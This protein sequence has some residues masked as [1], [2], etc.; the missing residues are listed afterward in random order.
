MMV[1]DCGYPTSTDSSCLLTNQHLNLVHRAHCLV[2]Q[3]QIYHQKKK[4]DRLPS[5][6]S[7]RC[8]GNRSNLHV[9]KSCGD[10]MALVP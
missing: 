8:G 4:H 3:S 10:C 5:R 7:L 6:I 9:M 2:N 1:Q